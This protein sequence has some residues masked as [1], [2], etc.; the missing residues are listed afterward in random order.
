MEGLTRTSS[1]TTGARADAS[2]Q[3]YL[4]SSGAEPNVLCIPRR[5]R[6]PLT[7]ACN[8]VAA[9]RRILSASAQESNASS[10]ASCDVTRSDVSGSSD[11][12]LCKLC[13]AMMSSTS[14]IQRRAVCLSSLKP[15]Q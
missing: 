9:S 2:V 15:Y 13:T 14:E 4:K 6:T 11:R 7:T 5:T 12:T 3:L 1:G 10:C 8:V